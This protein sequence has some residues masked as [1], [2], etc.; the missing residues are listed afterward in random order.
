[1][2]TRAYFKREHMNANKYP[3]LKITTTDN[4]MVYVK[5]PKEL[6]IKY[7]NDTKDVKSVRRKIVS[8]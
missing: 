6:V 5:G 7:K 4:G 1:M 2:T 8:I 3:G